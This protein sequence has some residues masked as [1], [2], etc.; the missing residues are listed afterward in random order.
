MT[1]ASY[2]ACCKWC[3]EEQWQSA[4]AVATT[5]L[6]LCVS[7]ATESGKQQVVVQGEGG[8]GATL[9]TRPWRD[10]DE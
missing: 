3:M 1:G 10:N 9:D 5:P 2:G 7:Y 8:G 4:N 6:D